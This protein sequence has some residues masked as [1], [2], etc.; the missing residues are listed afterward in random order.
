M[1]FFIIILAAIVQNVHGAARRVVDLVRHD[2]GT[3]FELALNRID[4][5]LH[6]TIGNNAQQ[7]KT[8]I[9]AYKGS[10]ADRLWKQEAT[11]GLPTALRVAIPGK[12]A[13]ETSLETMVPKITVPK[14]PPV[15]YT[16]S[17]R[18]FPLT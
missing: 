8:A 1:K 7:A 5:H 11:S 9:D 15:L 17:L 6:S 12:L 4:N 3:L 2:A 16:Q 13:A 10:R 14:P 18:G